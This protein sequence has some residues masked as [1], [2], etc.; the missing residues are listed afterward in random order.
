MENGNAVYAGCTRM[1]PSTTSTIVTIRQSAEHS[2]QVTGPITMWAQPITVELQSS[3]L[4]LFVTQSATT[5]SQTSASLATNPVST[6]LA[7][8]T[9]TGDPHPHT[10]STEAGIGIGV[11]VG[12]GGLGILGAVGFWFFQ[13][14]RKRKVSALN[15]PYQGVYCREIRPTAQGGPYPHPLEL[16]GA[17]DSTIKNVHELHG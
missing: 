9:T 5:A 2:T 3:D 11:G 4:S 14:R 10:I 8:T 1:L 13:R 16:D 12:V 15:D 6:S 17:E 7:E